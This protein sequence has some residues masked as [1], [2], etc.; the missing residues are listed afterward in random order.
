GGTNAARGTPTIFRTADSSLR[1]H[2]VLRGRGADDAV[3][4]VRTFT[5]QAFQAPAHAEALFVLP[6][7][8]ISLMPRIAWQFAPDTPRIAVDGWLQ[9]A[10]MRVGKGRAAFFGEAGMFSA[11]LAGAD[12]RPMGMNAPGAEQNHRFV[13]NLMRWLT[14]G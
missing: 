12:A 5:G 8:F 2:E 4:S 1:P 11:Q 14:T 13:L 3:T 7:G 6:E 10:V 9:G